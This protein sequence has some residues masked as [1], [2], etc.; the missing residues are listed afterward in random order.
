MPVP[1]RLD[2]CGLPAALSLTLNVPVLVPVAVGVNTTL[3]VQVDFAARLLVQV[4]ADSLK[5]P[6]T[7]IEMPVNSTLCLLASVNTFAALVDPTFVTGKVALAGV[8]VAC[9]VPVP[10]SATVCGLLA[11]LSMKATAPVAFQFA[12]V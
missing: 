4:V 10:V 8:S 3:I 9:T 6:L 5:S 12:S 1:V 11:A 2:A 7:S